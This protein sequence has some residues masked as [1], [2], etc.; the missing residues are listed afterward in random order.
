[1]HGL[2]SHQLRRRQEKIRLSYAARRKSLKN[3]LS[4]TPIAL[5]LGLSIDRR[6][7]FVENVNLEDEKLAK[8]FELSA[9]V[10]PLFFVV[11]YRWPL[12]SA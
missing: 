11:N 12:L 9:S 8:K 1:M 3:Y 2:V 4:S 7:S 6:F 5:N 10:K